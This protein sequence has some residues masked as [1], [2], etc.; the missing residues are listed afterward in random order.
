MAFYGLHSLVGIDQ[1]RYVTWTGNQFVAL[2]WMAPPDGE[3][4][5]ITYTSRDGITWTAQRNRPWAFLSSMVS[6]GK[7]MIAVGDWGGIAT[8][9]DGIKWTKQYTGINRSLNSIAWSSSRLVAVG[10]GT[11]LTSP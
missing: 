3:N 4:Y 10:N 2:A 5:F 6:T 9:T 11:I 7:V 1:P 8:S